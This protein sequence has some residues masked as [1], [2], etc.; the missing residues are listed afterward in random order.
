[1]TKNSFLTGITAIARNVLP[2]NGHLWLYGSR[3]RGESH[4]GSDWDLLILLN[5]DK[6]ELSDF[7]RYSYPLIEQGAEKGENVSAQIY[8]QNEWQAMSFTPFYKNVE[9]DKIVLI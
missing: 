9:R 7:D 4:E 5:K 1:M 3:A 6:Q 2:K 8:T